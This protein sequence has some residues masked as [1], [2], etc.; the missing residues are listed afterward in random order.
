MIDHFSQFDIRNAALNLN[1]IPVF[2]VH[3]VTGRDLLVTVAQV[4]R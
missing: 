2:L 4:E 1:G 3:V